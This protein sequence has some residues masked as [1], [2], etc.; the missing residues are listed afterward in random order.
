MTPDEFAEALDRLGLNG[1][2]AAALLGASDSRTIRRWKSGERDIPDHVAGILDWKLGGGGDWLVCA[3]ENRD[4]VMHMVAPR[5]VMKVDED[6]DGGFYLGIV[7]A[8]DP[9]PL[10]EGI[11]S[12]LATEAGDVW[13]DFNADED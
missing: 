3:D 8:F 7:A 6:G 12:A 4:Y 13:S 10:D 11:L 9:M 2:E 5:F 1:T